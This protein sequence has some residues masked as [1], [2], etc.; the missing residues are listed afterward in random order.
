MRISSVTFY[1]GGEL[2]SGSLRL[3]DRKGKYPGIVQGPGWMGVKDANLYLS[4]HEALTNSGFAVLVIDY[5]GFGDSGGPRG[6][7]SP[8]AQLEDLQNAVTF[9][10]AQNEIDKSRL[11]VFGTGGT[12]G[13][14]AVLLSAADDRILCAVSQVPVADGKDWLRRMRSEDDWYKYL[15]RLADNRVRLVTT[16]QGDLVDPTEEIMVATPERRSSQIKKDV[17]DSV[18][19]EVPLAA[20]DEI[21][22]YRPIDSAPMSRK[23]LVIAVEND[24]VTPTDHAIALYDAAPPPKK[25]IL[26]RNTTHYAAYAEYAHVIIPAIIAWFTE[27]L[28]SSAIDEVTPEGVRMLA[29]AP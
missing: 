3:P 6:L 1:S 9:M 19:K 24:A 17:A 25:L 7:L 29:E 11:G 23:L 2:V 12:G 15:Q 5:R 21:L 16:G 27:H 28:I 22:S 8:T 4:Y 18:P 26:Q 13:G 20:A 10:T 14:N